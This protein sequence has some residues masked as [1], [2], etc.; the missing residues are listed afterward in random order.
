MSSDLIYSDSS[1]FVRAQVRECGS[2]LL[3]VRM[4]RTRLL[5][6]ICVLLMELFSPMFDLFR[7]IVTIT[8]IIYLKLSNSRITFSISKSYSEHQV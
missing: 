8:Q 7:M 6:F 4:E 1:S 5:D 2:D 3:K